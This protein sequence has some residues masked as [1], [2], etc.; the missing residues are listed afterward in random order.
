MIS[1]FSPSRNEIT[2]IDKIGYTADSTIKLANVYSSY[3][4]LAFYK[5]SEHMTRYVW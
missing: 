1:C 3:V 2:F 5:W 4:V